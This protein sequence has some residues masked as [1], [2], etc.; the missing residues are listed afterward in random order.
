M[1]RED[2][3]TVGCKAIEERV[4]RLAAFAKEEK[5]TVG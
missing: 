3:Q 2:Y 1:S 5:E 4:S